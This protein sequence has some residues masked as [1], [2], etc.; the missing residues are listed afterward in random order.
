MVCYLPLTNAYNPLRF[1]FK[2]GEHDRVY[3]DADLNTIASH[4]AKSDVVY[5][6][7]VLFGC[8]KE[9]IIM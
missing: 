6:S 5:F 4:F 1:L 2:L 8:L 7:P 3:S 9:P